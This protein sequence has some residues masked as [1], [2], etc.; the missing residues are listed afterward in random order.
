MS[1]GIKGLVGKKL[2]KTVKFMDENVKIS[3]L[4]VAEV[5]EIQQHAKTAEA[6]PESTTNGFEVLKTVIKASVENGD[7]LTDEEFQGFPMDELAK[8]SAE[9]MKYSGIGQEQPGK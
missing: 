8:L 7:S 4:T 9:I 6:N 5:M 1:E 2:T 3:K